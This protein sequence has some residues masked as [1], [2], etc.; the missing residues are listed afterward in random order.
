VIWQQPWAWLG[1]LTIALPIVIHLLGRRRPRPIQFP[2]LR[3]IGVSKVAP[4]RR[5]RL[6]DIPLLI[7]RIAILLAAT[8]ALAQPWLRT[9]ER[10][11]VANARGASRALTRE[12]A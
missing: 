8:A 6:N 2:T 12:R 4:A 5:H 7:A 1:A 11:A 3:F 10:R 9:I